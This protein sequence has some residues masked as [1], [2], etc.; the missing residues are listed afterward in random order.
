[1]E[2][3]SCSL[4]RLPLGKT[5]WAVW[6]R[7]SGDKEGRLLRDWGGVCLKSS[8]RSSIHRIFY[9]DSKLYNGSL[10]LSI[11]HHKY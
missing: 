6:R 1:M 5:A 7:V 4:T 2:K 10:G 9:Y 11:E 8:R 3:G